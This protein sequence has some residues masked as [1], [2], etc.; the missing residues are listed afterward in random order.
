MVWTH[1]SQEL[2]VFLIESLITLKMVLIYYSLEISSIKSPMS[3][4]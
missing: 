3:M 2:S 4:S 1:Y